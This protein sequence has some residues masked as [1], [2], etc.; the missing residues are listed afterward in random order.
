MTRNKSF[1]LFVAMTFLFSG[2]MLSFGVSAQAAGP[3]QKSF[4]SPEAAVK[5]V[6]EAT[7][8]Y[9]KKEL[10]AILGH[11][12]EELISSGDALQDKED[13]EKFIKSYEQ[14]NV[15]KQI[16]AEQAVLH[17]GSEDWPF[18]IP[19]VKKGKD[20]FFDTKAGKQEILKR[21]IGRNELN[22]IE[23]MKAY[24]EAQREYAG[25]DLAGDHVLTFARKLISDPDMRD[26]LY[27]QTEEGE[28]KSPIG[29]YAAR[30]AK[31]ESAGRKG[32]LQIAP[33]YGYYYKVIS[34][35]GKHAEGGKYDYVVKGKM[36]LGFALAAFPARYGVSGIMSLIV[37]HQGVIYE[38]DLGKNT[39]QAVKMMKEFD[40]DETWKKVE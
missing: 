23:F 8:V 21:R 12:G 6:V 18:P 5:A 35:Q 26:G 14:K 17:V 9:N 37:N 24:V 19:I 3:Q 33:Y 38:K 29:L 4:A 36:T 28:A 25:K 22:T 27:W 11:E 31:F 40:P 1:F 34:A 2:I 39:D 30:A 20:W 13:R 15:L 10:L 7:K 32:E 16:T